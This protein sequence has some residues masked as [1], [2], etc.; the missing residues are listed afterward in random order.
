[1][2]LTTQNQENP[3]KK[4]QENPRKK[5]STVAGYA[6]SA[7]DIQKLPINRPSGR[8]TGLLECRSQLTTLRD[9]HS[10]RST[11]NESKL[12]DEY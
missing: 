2:N 4:H 11:F 6:R 8:Y 1:M 12:G 7:L 10:E 9:L 5:E 3:K